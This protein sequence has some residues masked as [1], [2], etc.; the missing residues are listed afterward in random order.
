MLLSRVT[1]TAGKYSGKAGHVIK[2]WKHN[3]TGRY[4]LDITIK[5]DCEHDPAALAMKPREYY[6][7]H[8]CPEFSY[9]VSVREERTLTNCQ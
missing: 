2:R 4:Y 9:V 8:T 7:L 1:I 6:Q 3:P 5:A